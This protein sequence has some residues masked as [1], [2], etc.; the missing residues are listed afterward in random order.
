MPKLR[1]FF[2]AV[3]LLCPHHV[4]GQ[5]KKP[6]APQLLGSIQVQL[7]EGDVRMSYVE[8]SEGMALLLHAGDSHVRARRLFL[9]DGKLAVAYEATQAGV[10]S[11]GRWLPNQAAFDFKHRSV[12]KVNREHAQPWGDLA[13]EVYVRLQGVEFKV[14]P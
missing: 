6:P 12:V 7:P 4:L 8:S 3:L 1:L 9:G 5:D 11:Q 10:V 14:D 13:G 2:A